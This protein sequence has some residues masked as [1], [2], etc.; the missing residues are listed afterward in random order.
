[1]LYRDQWISTSSDP[2]CPDVYYEFVQAPTD[3]A[4]AASFSWH[5]HDTSEIKFEI[6]TSDRSVEGVYTFT[7]YVGYC[8]GDCAT[9]IYTQRD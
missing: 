6:E 7:L 8:D 3:P 4:S 1:M 2:S 5:I 9:D